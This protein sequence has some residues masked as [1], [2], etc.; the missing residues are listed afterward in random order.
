MNQ[1]LLNR[2]IGSHP[3]RTLCRVVSTNRWSNLRLS[4][5]NI[6]HKPQNV[7]GPSC[8]VNSLA[9]DA[10]EFRYLLV[11]NSDCGIVLYDV[12]EKINSRGKIAAE[13][14][15]FVNRGN[16]FAHKFSVQ[17]VSWYP[18]DTGM[19]FSSSMDHKLK[20]WDTN[21]FQVACEFDL[22]YP[23]YSHSISMIS[24]T[25]L[26]IANATKD[27]L[28]YFVD[29]RSGSSVQRLKGHTDTVL[30]VCWSPS[31]EYLLA[32]GGNDG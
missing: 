15:N 18:H 20:V 29:L 5:E 8:G 19:F 27:S 7:F 31:D 30:S 26:L 11:G 6:I 9:F 4:Q 14:L 24:T 10:C 16:N 12:E 2:E 22:N 25:H 21:T 28:I 32:S 17:T 3:T 13:P 1:F 23:I